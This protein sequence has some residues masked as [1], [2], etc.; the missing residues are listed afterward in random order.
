MMQ[1]PTPPPLLHAAAL[2]ALGSPI[3]IPLALRHARLSLH[4]G[5]TPEKQDGTAP[6]NAFELRAPIKEEEEEEEKWTLGI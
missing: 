1:S 2:F 3:R 6:T 4:T 5:E